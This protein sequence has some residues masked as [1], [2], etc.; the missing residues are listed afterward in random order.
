MVFIY[1]NHHE[2]IIIELNVKME[3]LDH[4]LWSKWQFFAQSEYHILV[5]TVDQILKEMHWMC[6]KLRRWNEGKKL[7]QNLIKL[8]I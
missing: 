5:L 8:L 2:R 1:D 3:W 4:L 6:Y 7:I